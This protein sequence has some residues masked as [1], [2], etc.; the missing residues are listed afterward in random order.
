[1]FR[2]NKIAF[3]PL[4]ALT[5]ALFTTT[6][7]AA[8]FIWLEGENPASANVKWVAQGAERG[9]FLSESKWLTVSMDAATVDQDLPADGALI[10]Y[11]FSAPAAG[12]YEVW[13]RIGYEFVRA[14]YQ[15]R[16]DEG[17][18]SD[19]KPDDLTSDLMS[20][21]VWTEVAWLKVGVS[22]IKKGDH[23]LDLRV[24]KRLDDKGKTDRLI[25][26]LDAVCLYAGE[27]VPNGKFKP[28]ESGRE[29]ADDEAAKQVFALPEAATPAARASVSLAGAWE[30]CRNDEQA[31]GE[32]AVPMKDMPKNPIWKAIA[33]PSDKNKSRPDLMFAHRLW[34]RTRVDV[35]ASQ[36]GRSFFLVMPENSLNTTVFVN[37][38]YCGFDKNPFA[39]IQIDVTPAVK[40]GVNEVWVGIRDAWYGRAANPDKPMK[41]RKT[42]N[43]PDTAFGAGFQDLAYPVWNFA[44][45][46]ILQTPEFISAGP[47]YVTDV[48]CIPSV[49]KKELGLEITL[50]NPA[51]QAVSGEL[52]C[53]AVNDKTGKVEWTAPAQAVALE[54]A[55]DQVL[56]IAGKWET[57]ALWWPDEP[58]LYRLRTTLSIGGKPADV[59]ETRFGFREWSTEGAKFKLN[60]LTW[61]GRCDEGPWGASVDEGIATWRKHNQSMFRLRYR[62]HG[63]FGTTLGKTLDRLDEEGVI[64]RVEGVADGEMMGYR[65]REEDPDLKATNGPLKKDLIQNSRDQ[66]VAEIKGLRNHPSVAFWTLDNEMFFINGFN[67]LG[68]AN[69]KDMDAFEEAWTE[70]SNAIRA[71]DPTRFT[72]PEGGGAFKAHTLPVHGDHYLALAGDKIPLMPY[73]VYDRHPEVDAPSARGRWDWDEKQPRF[74]SEDYYADG[75]ATADFATL[76]GEACF[77]GKAG[78]RSTIALAGRMIMEGYRWVDMGAIDF[79]MWPSLTTEDLYN[80]FS[81]VAVFVKEYDWTFESGA[82]VARTLKIFN[83][84][85]F[86][87]PITFTWT[88]KVG[89]KTVITKTTTHTIAAGEAEEPAIEFTLP[90]VAART[91]GQLELTLTHRGKPAFS[92]TKAVSILNTAQAPPSLK[93]AAGGSIALFDPAGKVAPFLKS[94]GVKFAQVNS[95]EGLGPE[96]RIL[97]VGKDALDRTSDASTR[98]ANFAAAGGRVIVLDQKSPLRSQGLAPADMDIATN[99]G[100]VAFAEDLSHPV[101]KG[102]QQKDFFT[103]GADGLA[104]RNAYKK[105][106]A[107]ANSLIQ[108]HL[109]LANSALVEIPVNDGMMLLCQLLVEEKLDTVPAARQLLLNLIDYAASYQRESRVTAVASSDPQLLATLDAM[110]LK[111]TKAADPLQ[112]IGTAGVQLAVVSA[113]PENLKAL[114]GA[115]DKVNAYTAGGGAI[116]LNGLTPEGLADY[117]Q[118]VG[119]DHI[120]RPFHRERVSLAAVRNKLTSGLGQG[121]V[122]LLSAE[123]V[124][125]SEN[126]VANDT[127][128][129]VVDLDEVAAFGKWNN[130]FFNNL[131]NGMTNADNWRYIV[132][133]TDKEYIVTLPRAEMI[134][135]LTW[136]DNLNYNTTTHL[137]IVFDGKED[138]KLSIPVKP[139]NDPQIIA[140]DP[141]R[142]ATTVTIRHAEFSDLPGKKQL[143]GSDGVFIKAVRPADFAEKVK[144]MLNIGAMVEYPRGKGT[145]VLCNLLLKESETVPGNEIRKRNILAALLRNLHAPL[146]SGKVVIA[147]GGLDY[148]PVD[149]SKHANAYRNERGWYGDAKFTLKDIP[150]GKQ[151]LAGVTFDVYEFATSPVPTVLMLAGNKITAPQ[152]LPDKIEGIEVHR[153]ADA[154]FFLHTARI[155]K[156][157]SKD[158]VR[159]G[160]RSEVCRYVVHYADG[161]TADVPLY[162]DYNIG[163]F[164]VKELPQMPA[165]Q[166]AW[167]APYAGTE[168]NAAVYS[169]QWNNPRPDAEI[170]TVDMVYDKEHVGVPA[171]IAL[172]AANAR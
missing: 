128:A 129:Y 121:D 120:I 122:Q 106:R 148:T 49:A 153:K 52:L 145:I 56:K 4:L 164:K 112:A 10:Q 46:G 76:G 35:P 80:S 133:S 31:P 57:P 99:A 151:T 141:P 156:Q 96:V 26:A 116:L 37:G 15:W 91:E 16:I 109:K 62:G 155:D 67:G 63:F 3:L 47:A 103:W 5:L 9:Q 154:L 30:V 168:F 163:D 98:F 38:T 87:D 41:L 139:V 54:P 42:F 11:K 90:T 74:L 72:M 117:N 61:H 43:M 17:V 44:Q 14:P 157:P 70:T 108:C 77:Q 36:K 131:V 105:A 71:I 170:A 6:L 20:L 50:N 83:D 146:G 158:D 102:M 89:E 113:T 135:E 95:P 160:K 123:K 167:S 132:N 18:W 127:F 48:F 161:Q 39:R 29:D 60:G 149:L 94:A 28:G 79:A 23:T 100:N 22:D 33:V 159:K 97:V 142:Q 140:I 81:A 136:L 137:E 45:S 104:Y 101:L 86:A 59:Q 65:L 143:L 110:G 171:L 115:M 111:Y 34:Y 124:P 144:P 114:A 78:T 58:N 118:L 1:M 75:I 172:T 107:G 19:V 25:F 2:L 125:N 82:Q 147:G 169:M 7:R 126:F 55:K 92:D 162:L 51:A 53:E 152:P 73:W 166:V 27:F 134:R 84:T 69:S 13:H 21:G 24:T 85:R 12:K 64:T 88:L 8:D 165:A 40:T 150:T 66:L 68:G 138:E 93:A 119:V 32:V 130:G